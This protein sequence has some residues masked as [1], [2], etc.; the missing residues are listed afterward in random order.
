MSKA[1]DLAEYRA[2][3]TEN[4][5]E[6]LRKSL[7]DGVYDHFQNI[8]RFLE[9]LSGEETTELIDY[10]RHMVR[11]HDRDHL[12]ID[13]DVDKMKTFLLL[14]SK[15]SDKDDVDKV[16]SY[17]EAMEFGW[18]N[19]KYYLNNQC[20][21]RHLYDSKECC[22]RK[23]N[24]PYTEQAGEILQDI[25]EIFF[26]DE[27]GQAMLF[28]FSYC[29]TALFSSQ[30]NRDKFTVPFFLQIACDKTSV[31]Y[32]F[33]EEM[34]EICDVNSGLFNKCKRIKRLEGYCGY[35][36]QI[37]YPTQ[38]TSYD[39]DILCYNKDIPVFISGYEDERYYQSL[40]RQI[41]NVPYKNNTLDWKDTFNFL[42]IFVCPEI[43][44]SF[45]NIFSIDL[46]EFEISQ[47][48]LSLL[49]KRKQ[50]LASWSVELVM[51]VRKYLFQYEKEDEDNAN[52][53]ISHPFASYIG[54]YTNYISQKYPYLTLNN[55]KNVALL[56]FFYKGYLEVFLKSCTFPLE[57]E[58]VFFYDKNKKPLQL[59]CDK[60]IEKIT[61]RAE[62][63]LA[64]FHQRYLP[65]PKNVSV[66][67]KDAV[68]LAKQIQK[69]YQSMKVSLR[70]TPVEIKKDRYIFSL[71]TLGGTKIEDISKNA[72]TVKHRLKKYECFNLNMRS[73]TA[74]SL[75]VAEKQL[76]D[77]SL[78]EILGHES[79]VKSKMIIP[80]AVGFD[81]TGEMCIEDLV[82]MKHLLLGG[83]SS[84]GKST[85]IVS[86]LAS[87]AY[88][89]RT[90]NVNVLILDLLEKVDSDYN[91]FNDQPFMAAPV[92]RNRETAI[93]ALVF[94]Q[95]EKK[96]RLKCSNISEMPYIVCVIDEFPR[97][98]LNIPK[99]EENYIENIVSDL[100]SSARHVNIHL[101]LAAQNPVK[102]YMKGNIANIT[103]RMAFRCAHYQNSIAILGEGGAEK[104]I[105]RGQMLFKS[106]TG[107]KQRIQGSF[108]SEE[109][110]SLLLEDT[111]KTFVQK[112]PY[113]FRFKQEEVSDI[114][115]NLSEMGTIT[116]Q[117]HSD[118]L[119]A[120]VILWVLPQ[121]KVANSRIQAKF[122]IGNGRANKLLDQING[123]GLIERLHG[124]LGWKV[125]H[126]KDS[127]DAVTRYLLNCGKA[128]AEIQEILSRFKGTDYTEKV[129]AETK[130]IR[131]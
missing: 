93:K 40:Q 58:F 116:S 23:D 71:E 97:L 65:A 112:N 55:A 22:K 89:H 123:L 109:D 129:I 82:D 69:H 67:N 110:R 59:T 44:T 100:L 119:L 31:L 53:L 70:V 94:L 87:I 20:L 88:K 3:S 47:A 120:D 60:N 81:E 21:R 43:K 84:S 64:K 85:A 57:A 24:V 105:G 32:Q 104:L 52:N 26:E 25:Y 111:K 18:H 33:I 14:F 76:T 80:Y 125:L 130:C 91:I 121:E 9:N 15:L 41:A 106:M 98:F 7:R 62:S 86:L 10:V 101:I 108:I 56:N 34:I 128:E 35:K 115:E 63:I 5:I 42:P 90:G 1:K 12:S 8:E 50:I 131:E 61:T 83:V 17:F 36:H 49:R 73:V 46:S 77:N 78:I 127:H 92:I 72:D 103:A 114:F 122:K 107:E 126:T 27:I 51:D 99:D 11:N 68:Q 45:D 96:R 4:E 66:K 95:E 19:G 75:V 113:P 74:I 30:L 38:A 79:F 117:A 48:K 118:E 6:K 39:L 2:G 54:E 28:I 37:Y 29:L 102:K 124:N 16:L 13:V